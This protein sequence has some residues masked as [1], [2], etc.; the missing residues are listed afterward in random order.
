MKGS[1]AVQALGLTKVYAYR[2]AL[3][4]LDLEL[5]WGKLLTVFGPNGSGKST[6]I[7]LLAGLARPSQGSV[8]LAGLDPGRAPAQARSLLG[9]V[10]HQTFLYDDLTGHENLR[11]YARLFG[12]KEVDQRIAAL[13]RTL[14]LEPYLSARVGSLSHGIQKRLSMARAL[15]HQPTILLLD[16]PETGLDQEALGLLESLLADHRGAGGSVVLTTHSL[17]GGLGMAD[18]VAI[19]SRGRLAYYGARDQLDL[20]AFRDTYARATEV[21]G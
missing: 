10:T 15:I 13:A 12:V 6:L 1:A 17:E 3:R 18:Q 4:G 20:A 9:V 21:S 8:R 5:P 2:P 7:R 14:A 11:F 19:L 16:E